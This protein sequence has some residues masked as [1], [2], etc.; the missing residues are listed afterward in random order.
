VATMGRLNKRKQQLKR[1]AKARQ[2]RRDKDES[3]CKE[4]E[5]V[6]MFD[7]E[8]TVDV[9]VDALSEDVVWQEKELEFEDVQEFGKDEAEQVRGQLEELQV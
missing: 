9:D 5:E 3:R 8:T 4:E 2:A 1:L 7:S 6:T